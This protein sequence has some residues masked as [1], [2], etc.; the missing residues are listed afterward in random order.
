MGEENSLL[1]LQMTHALVDGMDKLESAHNRNNYVEV[2]KAKKAL[3]EMQ[4]RLSRI[5][6]E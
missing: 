1:I 5:L 2:E 3:L 4:E 6:K